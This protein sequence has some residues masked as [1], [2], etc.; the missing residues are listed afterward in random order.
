MNYISQI[1]EK[2][3]LARFNN[4]KVV[5]TISTKTKMRPEHVSLIALSLLLV[6]FF[7]TGLGHKI[8]LVLLSF[9]YPAYKSF[10]ALETEDRE[11]D[12]RWL[13]Y[14]IVFGFVFAFKNLFWGL[15]TLF[16]GTNLIL[17]LILASVYCPLTNGHI[18]IYEYAF[19]PVLKSY[20][21]S[22]RKYIDMAKE[23]LQDKASRGGKLVNEKLSK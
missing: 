18:Y 23:E 9:L 22:I 10:V 13:V 19:K 8:L 1:E 4:V 17:S 2:L 6:F 11:D 16:P 3:D 20:Q 21:C 15:L 5:Q 12:K 14:W 7:L